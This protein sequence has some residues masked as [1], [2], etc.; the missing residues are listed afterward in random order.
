MLRLQ[1]Y[2]YLLT[3]L[4]TYTYYYRFTLGPG[5]LLNRCCTF[6][7]I[8]YK[9]IFFVIRQSAGPVS[10]D[11]DVVYS[12]EVTTVECLM[13]TVPLCVLDLRLLRTSTHACGTT[14]TPSRSG[15]ALTSKN[16]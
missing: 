9:Q 14:D 12:A 8:N 11:G 2:Y 16:S 10:C 1:L 15:T 13:N 5:N 4:L 6:A 3:Y 7:L